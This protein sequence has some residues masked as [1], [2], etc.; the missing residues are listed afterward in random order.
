MQSATTEDELV[1]DDFAPHVAV[2]GDVYERD[3]KVNV[4]IEKNIVLRDMSCFAEGMKAMFCLFYNLDIEYPK[5]KQRY[6]Y[7]FEFVQKILF[8]LD[9]KK[10]S[11]KL[12]TFKNSVLK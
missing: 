11:P 4:V 8:G 5:H 6:L 10:L 1:L 3:S 7:Y 2:I 9:S 12:V